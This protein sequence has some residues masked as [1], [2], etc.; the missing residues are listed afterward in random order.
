MFWDSFSL[1]FFLK[2]PAAVIVIFSSVVHHA[3]IKGIIF[4]PHVK[5]LADFSAMTFHRLSISSTMSPSVF[6]PW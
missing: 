6:K 4:Y 1:S 3:K 5:I 2:K